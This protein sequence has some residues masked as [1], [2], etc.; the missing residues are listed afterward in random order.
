MSN[1]VFLSVSCKYVLLP[2]VSKESFG[3]WQGIIEL[4]RKTKLSAGRKKRWG[5]GD[6]M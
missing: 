3:L 6:A 2:L 1:V 4:G 5:Q